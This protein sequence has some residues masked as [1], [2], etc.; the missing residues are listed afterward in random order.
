M[1]YSNI[2]DKIFF[3][4]HGI[5]KT[6]KMFFRGEVT[7]IAVET[8]LN[9]YILALGD[10]AGVALG[11][12]MRQWFLERV[13]QQSSC[14]FTAYVDIYYADKSEQERIYILIDTVEDFFK[15]NPKWYQEDSLC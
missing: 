9:G 15:E 12:K 13:K 6:P 5:K 2:N 3:H 1:D 14:F 11:D 8:Y 4:I 10:S 7:Y